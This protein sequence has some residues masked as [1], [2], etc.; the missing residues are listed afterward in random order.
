MEPKKTTTLNTAKSTIIGHMV[1]LVQDGKITAQDVIK[2]ES[3]GVLPDWIASMIPCTRTTTFV[4]E[5]ESKKSAVV[6]SDSRTGEEYDIMEFCRKVA[7]MESAMCGDCREAYTEAL[8]RLEGL[9]DLAGT[10][11]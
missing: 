11:L 6:V 5:P 7:A 2:F 10:K 9:I 1:D 8:A 4:Q 3:S